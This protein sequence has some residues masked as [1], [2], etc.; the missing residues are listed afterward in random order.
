M[1]E[2]IPD[3]CTSTLF[4]FSWLDSRNVISSGWVFRF[5]V[6]LLETMLK[7]SN[8]CIYLQRG[9]TISWGQIPG[10]GSACLF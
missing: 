6:F 10:S 8:T 7:W 9:D 4:F 2:F 3:H 1:L 5:V